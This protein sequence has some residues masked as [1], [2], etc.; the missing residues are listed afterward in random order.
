[1]WAILG[2]RGQALSPILHFQEYVNQTN[3][4]TFD[5]P[6]SA[7]W[8]WGCWKE[9]GGEL[10]V[11]PCLALAQDLW[12][13]RGI[14]IGHCE[15][16]LNVCCYSHTSGT[17]IWT[18]AIKSSLNSVF[19]F[20]KRLGVVLSQPTWW[21]TAVPQPWQRPSPSSWFWLGRPTSSWR[22]PPG[23]RRGAITSTLHKTIG[24]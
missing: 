20:Y 9:R 22:A 21:L 2:R 23:W 6:W 5:Q 3:K 16:K 7:S 19:V 10:R 11:P 4:C 24:T 17:C 12:Q 18:L 14:L 1:M 13:L 8:L 15:N